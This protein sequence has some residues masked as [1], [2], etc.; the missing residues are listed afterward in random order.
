GS[1]LRSDHA[2]VTG[3]RDLWKAEAAEGAPCR[4]G[5]GSVPMLRRRTPAGRGLALP[6]ALLWGANGL[7]PPPRGTAAGVAHRAGGGEAPRRRVFPPSW[8]VDRRPLAAWI[9]DPGPALPGGAAGPAR[10]LHGRIRVRPRSA[11]PGPALEVRL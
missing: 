5:M 1:R 2:I 8:P 11:R 4:P 3:S 7:D 9:P 6:R 10:P